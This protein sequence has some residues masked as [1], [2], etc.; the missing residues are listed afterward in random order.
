[1][2]YYVGLF[3]ARK[4]IYKLKSDATMKTNATPFISKNFPELLEYK[5]IQ[6]KIYRKKQDK[7][8]KDN[9]WFSFNPDNL[10]SY[11]FIVFAGALDDTNKNFR[12]LKVPTSYLLQNIDKLDNFGEKKTMY[13]HIKDLIDLRNENHLPFSDFAIN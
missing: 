11:N 12:I 9:W 1:M 8:Y 10:T 5:K 4:T 7:L 3:Q 13:I 2:R 6:S